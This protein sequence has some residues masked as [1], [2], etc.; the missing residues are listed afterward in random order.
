MSPP[1]GPRKSGAGKTKAAAPIEVASS[2]LLTL[3][4]P[5]F[6][7]SHA[8][9]AMLDAVEDLPGLKFHDLYEAY[10]DF[11][12]DVPL[13][14][15]KLR[16]HDVIAL[17]FPLHWYA[18]PALLKEWFDQVWLHGF[19]YGQGGI[20]L[21]GKRLFVAATAGHTAESYHRR[22]QDRYSIDEFLRPLEQTAAFC[23]M[24]WETPFIVHNAVAKSA[25]A[26]KEEAR[27]YR[28][29]LISL[30]T[31]PAGD[32]PKAADPESSGEAG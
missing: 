12:V 25:S 23:G 29:R 22:G 7:R 3:A 10:P 19:A 11:V 16:R 4:H 27:R 9:R 13:E 15:K 8:N 2:L 20:A 17:Q 18:P 31:A 26:L 24:T 32:G 1:P 30:I 6:E 21:K 28:E 14:Q 5:A